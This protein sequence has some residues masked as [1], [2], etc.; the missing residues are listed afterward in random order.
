MGRARAKKLR[1]CVHRAGAARTS[2]PGRHGAQGCLKPWLS[3][4]FFLFFIF[5]KY[6]CAYVHVCACVSVCEGGG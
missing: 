1:G 3:L 5:K 6:V 2:G 4:S